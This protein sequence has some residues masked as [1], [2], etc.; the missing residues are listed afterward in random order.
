M[1][2]GSYKY[3]WDDS[4]ICYR[5]DDDKSIHG[6]GFCYC[7]GDETHCSLSYEDEAEEIL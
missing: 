4:E 1:P 5:Q 3:K 2:C 6:Y 7:Q